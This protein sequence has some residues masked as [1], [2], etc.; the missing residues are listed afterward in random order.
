MENMFQYNGGSHIENVFEKIREW[1]FTPEFIAL[2][3]DFG[4]NEIPEDSLKGQVRELMEFSERWD[5]RGKQ[6]KEMSENAESARWMIADYDFNRQQKDRVMKAANKLGLIG[7]TMPS[8][9]EYDYMLVLGGARMSCLFRMK[10]AKQICD[11]YNIKVKSMVGLAGMRGVMNT[12]R[13]ATNT[14]APEADTEFD[15]MRAALFNV[16]G[17]LNLSDKEVHI[18]E[19][20]NS[21]WA[22]EVYYIQD[23]PVTL[24]AAPS[25]APEK[26]RANTSDTFAF[27]M[28]QL[29]VENR[30][31]ILLVTSQIY[32]PYQ[33]LEAIRMLGI[34]YEHSLETIGFPNEWSAGLQGMQKTENYL[35]EMRSVLQSANRLL[36]QY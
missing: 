27:F 28:N 10:Y 13:E 6:A 21:S 33:Q 24:L 30:K 35:Q 4:K 20:L 7:C 17:E 23:I 29:Q 26:R 3:Q 36:I 14:Y 15:L 19:N 5:F 25:G 16:F 12:E 11:S 32:V 22:K 31:N 1:I 9:K 8:K 2:L 18:T 34:P